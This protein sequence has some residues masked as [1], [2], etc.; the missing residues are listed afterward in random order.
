MLK[1]NKKRVKKLERQVGRKR[2]IP[3]IEVYPGETQEQVKEKY[4]QENPDRQEGEVF[5]VINYSQGLAAAKT[6]GG[7]PPHPSQEQ[8]QAPYRGELSEDVKPLQIT[9]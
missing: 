5:L 8:P 9:R 6:R 4:L 7:P 1:N 3:I 2:G